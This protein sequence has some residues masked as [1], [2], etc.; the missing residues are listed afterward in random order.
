[1]RRTA[2]SVPM[3]LMWALLAMLFGGVAYGQAL[4]SLTV[5]IKPLKAVNDTAK[6]RIMD[7]VALDNAQWRDSGFTKYQ[8]PAGTQV[9]IEFR[10]VDGV[11]NLTPSVIVVTV[12]GAISKTGYYSGSGNNAGLCK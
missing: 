2:M 12:N 4:P 1:M 5:E 10:P 7:P 9:K 6:W 11:C 3:I 8:I